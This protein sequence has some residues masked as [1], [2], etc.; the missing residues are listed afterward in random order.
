MTLPPFLTKIFANKGAEIVND[1]LKG[2]DDLFTSKEEMEAKK[3]EFQKAIDDH[4][5]YM[6]AEAN[7]E[8]EM[9]LSD[10]QSARE[11]YKDSSSLQKVYAVT[12]LISYVALVI[13]LLAMAGNVSKLPDYAQ[14]LVSTIFGAMSTKVG[15][16]TDFLFGSSIGSKQ[17]QQVIESK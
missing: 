13:T 8:L 5:S 14:M 6:K 9:V 15:T 16:I 1:V 12:F 3:I 10:K 11:M 2:A 17:K 7:K 4:I